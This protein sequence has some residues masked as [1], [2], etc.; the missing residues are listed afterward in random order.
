MFSVRNVNLATTKGRGVVAPR[1]FCCFL[2]NLF[3][4]HS[5]AHIDAM[6]MTRDCKS[7]QW[8]MQMNSSDCIPIVV[9]VVEVCPPR[10]VTAAANSA[11]VIEICWCRSSHQVV[12]FLVGGSFSLL[13]ITFSASHTTA[14]VWC[15]T[16]DIQL[17]PL[18]DASL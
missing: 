5:R 9:F 13:L 8:Y 10:S 1:P 11:A 7:V 2:A 3:R 14:F 15:L 4:K 16:L 18:C 6:T 17:L 12:P